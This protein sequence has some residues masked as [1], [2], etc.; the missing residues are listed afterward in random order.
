MG[1]NETSAEIRHPKKLAFLAAYVE[2]CSIV[3]AC[4]AAEI[5]R[6]TQREWRKT[7]PVFAQAFEDARREAGETLEAEAVRRAYEGVEEATTVAGSR[8]LVRKYS[9]TLL[10][11]MLKGTLPDRYRERFDHR[12]GGLPGGPPIISGD[13]VDSILA[14]LKGAQS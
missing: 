12:I 14:A 1:P 13:A 11:F 9:D 3:R 8:E 10:I 4:A 5:N 6:D 2:T 7:D